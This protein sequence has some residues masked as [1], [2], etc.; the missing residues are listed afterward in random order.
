MI[1]NLKVLGLALVAMFAMSAVVASMASAA[2]ETKPGLFTASVGAGETAKIDVEQLL[3]ENANKEKV[4]PNTFTLNGLALTCATVTLTGN[5]VKTKASPNQDVVEANTK[6][7]ESTDVTL[8]PIFG[9]NNCHVVI[10]GLTK[11]VTVTT[12]GCAFVFDAQTTVT[13]PGFD[14]TV[15][16][17]VECPVVG[18]VQKKI[19]VHVYGEKAAEATT[20]C[21]YDIEAIAANTTVPGITLT[22]KVNTPTST[23][24]ILAKLNVNVSVNNTIKSAVCGL[25]ATENAVYEG[26][27]TVQATNEAGNLVDASVSS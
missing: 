26:E 8:S 10:A 24:D 16:N 2:E 4:I 21:T 25:N 20:T 13:E 3:T 7:P 9:P 15:L 12:N 23:N 14:N 1:R 19:E 6:G 27:A 11:T 18:G 17:T 22:N 5:P